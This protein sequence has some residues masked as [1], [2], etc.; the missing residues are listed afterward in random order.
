[1][2]RILPN[3]A[4]G[5]AQAQAGDCFVSSSDA[6]QLL[7][8]P[9]F[10]NI[11]VQ[12]AGTGELQ[13][14]L[15]VHPAVQVHGGEAHFFDS[16]PKLRC[17][18]G[19]KQSRLRLTYAR[20]LWGRKQLTRTQ[21]ADRVAYE[22]TPAYFDLAEPQIVTCV[23][24]AA[25]FVVM[26]RLPAAR[27][28]SAY[29]MCQETLKQRWCNRPAETAFSRLLGGS[30]RQGGSP[31]QAKRAML[32][33]VP[34]L[35]RILRIGHYAAHLDRWLAHVPPERLGV[36]W[37]EQF[38]ADPFACMAAVERF[39]QLPSHD[40]HTRAYKNTAGYWVVGKSKSSG[41]RTHAATSLSARNLLVEYYRPWQR[42]LWPLID[43]RNLS[44]VHS[45]PPPGDEK[46][47]HENAT[48]TRRRGAR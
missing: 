22:K 28:L 24:P 4:T 10:V 21:M 14:W 17:D 6:D 30:S 20:F 12:K 29:R 31:P 42:R 34:Q 1:M 3:T 37:V 13:S 47:R 19:R 48:S 26:L 45:P 46:L 44:L 43:T 5:A 18:S 35:G 23:L 39:A 9:A 2:P 40:Y 36:V 27:A 25:R 16:R 11:G 38:K 41:V 33:R 15:D 7:C 32:R 8:L